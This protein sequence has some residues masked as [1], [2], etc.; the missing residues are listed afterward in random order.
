MQEQMDNLIERMDFKAIREY[1]Q[2]V[3]WTWAGYLDTPS[4][5]AL[6][7]TARNVLEIAASS[8]RENTLAATGGFVAYKFTW[9]GGSTE[10]RLGFEPWTYS[11]SFRPP[12]PVNVYSRRTH[13]SA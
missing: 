11:A 2:S 13:R 3:N 6:K 5:D 7:R 4:I 8:P 9:D 1:M 12:E 10:L